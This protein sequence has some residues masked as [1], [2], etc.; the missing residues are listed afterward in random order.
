MRN[1]TLLLT[2]LLLSMTPLSGA[3]TPN[4]TVTGPVE[5][6]G[7]PGRSGHDY[8][9]FATNHDLA[10]HGYIEEEF[11]IEGTASRYN[12][13]AQTTG[14]VTDSGHAYRTRIVVRRPA[15]AKRFNGTV[16][17]EWYNVTNNFD[18]ENVWFFAWEHML[19]GGYAWVG[20]SAQQVGVRALKT[21]STARYGTVDV[22]DN[23]TVM[24][25]ALSYDIFSQAGQAIKS[26]S[27][28]DML[29]GL[30]ARHVF[31]VGESQSAGR[32]ATY[33]NSI[34]P[35]ANI[36]D[37][38][39]LLSALNQ[40]IRTDLKVPVWKMSAEYDV[41]AGE[42]NRRQPDTEMIRIWEVAG[43][44]HVDHHLRMSRE[45]LELRDIGPSSE[46]MMATSC[47]V[48]T[49]GTR[50]PIQY[51]IAAVFD[52]LVRWVEKRTPPPI[53]LP[54]T[55]SSFGPPVVVSRNKLGL[56][57]GGIRLP[58]VAVPIAENNGTN[59][60]PGACVRWGYYK[61]FDIETLN[62]L[63]PTH[64][65]YVNSVERVANENVRAGYILKPDAD[66]MIREAKDS[67][68]GRL[69]SP[70]AERTRPMSDFDKN[71]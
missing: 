21:F 69:D 9:F 48:P 35:L 59:S 38:F 34:H 32:L 4:P 54:I 40:K 66:A 67:A 70:E 44:S 42:A 61:P 36:Y 47:K 33:A 60:G 30:K 26:P 57:I 23:G 65:S 45:P 55:I 25:D 18:A 12:T 11:F 51:I 52:G 6:H 50:V 62:M 13:P 20:V 43:T 31:A 39:F 8:T 29:G 15:D 56:V 68:I 17:V 22:T 3:S 53:A 10:S 37:G 16:L 1:V 64:E 63:Y 5:A 46:A 28:T 71:P 24:N 2:V 7:I 14:T 41:A 49:V 19:R 58:Q 27:G